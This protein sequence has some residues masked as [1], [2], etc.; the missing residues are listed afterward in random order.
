M[1]NYKIFVENT[2]KHCLSGELLAMLH[3]EPC[4]RNP[5]LRYNYDIQHKDWIKQY[6]MERMLPTEINNEAFQEETDIEEPNP[7]RTKLGICIHPICSD[8]SQTMKQCSCCG[9]H[10]KK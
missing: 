3:D 8:I 4:W 6:I 5:Y 9:K 10:L 7:K 1:S 2:L